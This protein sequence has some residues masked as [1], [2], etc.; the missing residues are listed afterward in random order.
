MLPRVY[1]SHAAQRL[2]DLIDTIRKECPCDTITVISHSQGTMIAMGATLLCK[3][4]APDAL[5]VINSP[6]ARGSKNTLERYRD[7]NHGETFYHDT[8]VGI[9]QRLGHGDIENFRRRLIN[10]DLSGKNLVFPAAAPPFMASTD[11][12]WTINFPYSKDGGKMFNSASYTS[13]PG[14]GKH[15]T[16][17]AINDTYLNAVA[18]DLDTAIG[19]PGPVNPLLVQALAASMVQHGQGTHLSATPHKAGMMLNFVGTSIVPIENVELQMP[20]MASISVTCSAICVCGLFA[21]MAADS[22]LR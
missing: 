17:T 2:A 5:F 8:N 14:H 10:A 22:G 7:C 19:L 16:L 3:T 6:Y 20:A 21:L 4:R 13:L 11:R 9:R 12:D 1:F 18:H 15:A